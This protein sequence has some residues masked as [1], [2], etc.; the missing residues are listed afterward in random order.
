MQEVA[1]R[2]NADHY[3]GTINGIILPGVVPDYGGQPSIWMNT[4]S[5]VEWQKW[6]G[7]M[8]NAARQVNDEW[9][10]DFDDD[11]QEKWYSAYADGKLTLEVAYKATSGEVFFKSQF[12]AVEA[13]VMLNEW[14]IQQG[15]GQDGIVLRA[16]GV[17]KGGK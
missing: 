3:K 5:D 1:E 15:L 11:K 8:I 2:V 16:L 6:V 9:E 4:K 14:S 13:L 7:V 10:A 17:V 12:A